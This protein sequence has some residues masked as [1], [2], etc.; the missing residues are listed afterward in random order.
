[1]SELTSHATFPET[2]KVLPLKVKFA[3]PF[4]PEPL[5][6]VTTRLLEPFVNPVTA[7]SY[8]HLRAHET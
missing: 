4:N 7:V 8:T 3:S 6:A 1:M 2:V 5:V